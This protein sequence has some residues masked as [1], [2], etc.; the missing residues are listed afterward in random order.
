MLSDVT[1]AHK[2]KLKKKVFFK[3]D[4]FISFLQVN[5]SV[6]GVH[7]HVA[8]TTRWCSDAAGTAR[9]AAAVAW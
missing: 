6:V 1:D 2:R 9:L 7:A 8:R 4:S 5:L 3:F